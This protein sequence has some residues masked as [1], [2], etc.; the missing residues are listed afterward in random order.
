[1]EKNFEVVVMMY[2][3][4]PVVPL[5]PLCRG[6]RNGVQVGGPTWHVVVV[7]WMLDGVG[8]GKQNV[9]VVH[10]RNKWGWMMKMTSSWVMFHVLF[11]GPCRR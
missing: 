7:R 5:Q 1:M 10:K 8:I 11:L 9:L 4:M 6:W 3:G 2:V